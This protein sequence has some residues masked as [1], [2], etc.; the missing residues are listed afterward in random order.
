MFHHGARFLIGFIFLGLLNYEEKYSF[1]NGVFN[2][3][4]P[5]LPYSHIIF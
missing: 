3:L 1:K 4:V 5:M 2:T